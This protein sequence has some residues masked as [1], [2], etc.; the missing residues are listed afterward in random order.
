MQLLIQLELSKFKITK[1]IISSILITF[2]MC[3]FTTVTLLASEQDKASN[4][5]EVVKMMNVAIL[6]CY[7]IF[8]SILIMK[9]IVEEYIKK[10]VLI[11]FTYSVNR[12]HLLVAKLLLVLGIT[13]SF[14]VVTGI[15]CIAYLIVVGPYMKLSL[16]TFDQVDFVYWLTQFGWGI[17][18]IICFTLLCINIAFIKKTSQSVFLTSL[19]SIIIIQIIISQDIH[20]FSLVLGVLIFILTKISL[21]KYA[22]KLE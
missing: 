13:V 1:Y 19:F 20:K 14:T 22:G 6:D 9:V 10:T 11:L 7:L 15:I 12:V 5:T 21:D 8:S 4:Y 2:G 3:L 17:V 16:P 18:L